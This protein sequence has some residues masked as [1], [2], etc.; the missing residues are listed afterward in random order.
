MKTLLIMAAGM[1]SRYGGNK[2]TDG[3]GPCG[4]FIMDYSLYD[5]HREGFD[6]AVFVIKKDDLELFEGSVGKRISGSM[7]VEYVFQDINDIPEGIKV[8]EGRIKPWGTAHA[9]YCARKK[10]DGPFAVINADDFY[11][12]GA[13]KNLNDFL[14]G[15]KEHEYCMIGYKLINTL[16]ENGSVSRGVCAVD[17]NGHLTAIKE[18]RFIESQ[19]ETIF[20]TFE[21]GSRKELDPKTIVSMNCWGFMPDFFD[22]I[23]RGLNGFFEGNKDNLSKCEYY[24]L[25]PVAKEIGSK[26][27]SVKVIP[28][29]E[30][31]FGVT[32]RQDR[33]NVK[34]QIATLIEKGVY[35][36]NLWGK[37]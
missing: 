27:A 25:E 24:L 34:D 31:W 14:C 13:F 17:A 22:V 2:Q 10:I 26:A 37:A 1:G 30:K 3:F 11:G 5:A 23:G 8:P 19:N 21:D 4:E 35:P 15:A 7:P 9:V 6:K 36:A 33:D 28:T 32:Y 12:R 18:D 29:N 16:T 20:N